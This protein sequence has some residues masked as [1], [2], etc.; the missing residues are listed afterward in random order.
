V[1][2]TAAVLGSS[3]ATTRPRRVLRAHR[4][5]VARRRP[6]RPQVPAA[7]RILGDPQRVV[8]VPLPAAHPPGRD[9]ARPAA[10]ARGRPGERPA[11]AA[12]S[13]SPKGRRGR[14]A[15]LP[16]AAG[17]GRCGRPSARRFWRGWRRGLRTGRS[18]TTF[19]PRH[20]A[21]PPR[22][23]VHARGEEPAPPGGPTRRGGRQGRR[24]PATFARRCMR[25]RW[26]PATMRRRSQRTPST[27]L[28]NRPL[29]E[30]PAPR[31]DA[32]SAL[33]TGR[34]GTAPGPRS[35]EVLPPPA[36][37]TLAGPATA[38]EHGAGPPRAG[39]R[40]AGPGAPAH[41]NRDLC[42][43]VPPRSR[44]ARPSEQITA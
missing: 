37:T 18:A 1:M 13:W 26:A 27:A 23:S 6:A 11:A 17:A 42:G 39:S 14:R 10:V 40:H 36:A 30:Q 34:T 21:G 22:R 29:S 12:R 32:T 41:G 44:L 43:T 16:R 2:T 7:A 33:R 28:T 3:G 25:R 24:K 35:V 9:A 19:T 15:G 4:T 20:R 38:W 31:H 5:A 8:A